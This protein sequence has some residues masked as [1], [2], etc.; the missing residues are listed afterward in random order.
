MNCPLV[1]K[2]QYDA[3]IQ[4][5]PYSYVEID[6]YQFVKGAADETLINVLNEIKEALNLSFSIQTYKK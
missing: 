6:G 5:K 2:Q 3:I 4:S 1:S